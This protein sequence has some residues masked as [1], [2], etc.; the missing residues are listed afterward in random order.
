LL[1]P[2][3]LHEPRGAE[4]EALEIAGL[5][6]NDGDSNGRRRFVA[7]GERFEKSVKD[8][9]VSGLGPR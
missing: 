8:G 6:E 3:Q 4:H 1:R 7:Y 9:R 5:R 2:S